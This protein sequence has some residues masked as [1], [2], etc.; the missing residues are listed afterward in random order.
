MTS[1][2][3]DG[4][5]RQAIDRWL[6]TF[7]YRVI[8]DG[9]APD[10]AVRQKRN[11]LEKQ[12]LAAGVD[13][14]GPDWDSPEQAA[15][16][17][18]AD[19][20]SAAGGSTVS[21]KGVLSAWLLQLSVLTVIAGLYVWLSHGWSILLTSRG[22][23]LSAGVAV[24][25]LLLFYAVEA[26]KTGRITRGVALVA[27]MIG[28]CAATGWLTTSTTPA[29]LGV[30]TCGM[31]LVLGVAFG[32]LGLWMVDAEANNLWGDTAA[33]G[34]TDDIPEDPAAWFGRLRGLLIARYGYSRSQANATIGQL[35]DHVTEAATNPKEEYGDP[36]VMA[37]SL[38][39]GH[40]RSVT[41]DKW[42][43]AWYVLFTVI[44]GSWTASFLQNNDPAH[45]VF[46]VVSAVLTIVTLGLAINQIRVIRKRVHSEDPTTTV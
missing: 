2:T 39:G 1:Q 4:A 38:A 8:I 30:I 25:V 44:A 32:A 12:L 35:V 20:E 17:F 18:L 29:P 28:G 7:V 31:I 10:S 46:G 34:T 9:D 22:L 23:I 15:E 11:E 45:L 26:V 21:A 3:T 36:A 5:H 37:H 19:P 16:R 27:A 42:Q 41:D 14:F 24:L 40:K 6:T 43:L 13:P 33:D